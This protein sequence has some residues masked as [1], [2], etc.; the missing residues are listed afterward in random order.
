MPFTINELTFSSG[1][2]SLTRVHVA[3]LR[4]WLRDIPTADITRRYFTVAGEAPPEKEVSRLILALRDQLIPLCHQH[5]MVEAAIGLRH[6][7][8]AASTH[9]NAALEAILQIESRLAPGQDAELGPQAGQG[10]ELWFTATLARRFQRAG[11]NTFQDILEAFKEHGGGWWRHAPR[12]GAKTADVVLRWMM[13]QTSLAEAS[14]MAELQ[15]EYLPPVPAPTG[16]D[17]VILGPSSP[18]VPWE[19]IKSLAST[20]DGTQGSNRGPRNRMDAQNDLAAIRSWLSLH[21][22]TSHTH[23]AY[24]KEAERF[25]LW[26]ILERGKPLSSLSTEDAIA[27]RDF[28]GNIP[29]HWQGP[30]K[31]RTSPLWRPFALGRLKPQPKP[32]NRPAPPA[33]MPHEPWKTAANRPPQQEVEKAQD[34]FPP[35]NAKSQVQAMTILKALCEWLMRRGYLD[36]NPFDGVPQLNITDERLNLRKAFPEPVWDTLVDWLEEQSQPPANAQIRAARAAILV[37]RD[38]GLRRAEACSLCR[39]DLVYTVGGGADSWE[40]TVMGKGRKRRTI[41]TS[42]R[43]VAAL[44]AHFEDR[45]QEWETPDNP[46]LLSPLTLI[47]DKA[48]ERHAQA[49]AGY[50]PGS[51]YHLVK[52][53]YKA[54]AAAHGDLYGNVQGHS[55]KTATVHALRH[56]FGVHAVAAGVELDVLQSVLGHAS[57][58]T[59]TI[60]VQGDRARRRSQLTE[61]LYR[62]KDKKPDEV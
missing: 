27:Y 17:L 2:V 28:L 8:R 53:T 60:Y 12:I 1:Q 14:G 30:P 9:L 57:L 41:P 37:L 23:R 33:D 18:L 46:P 48:Q 55:M 29:L 6:G 52:A 59:T 40:I 5:G 10:V 35:L 21:P 47:S 58:T 15:A 44:K 34:R 3:A 42:E 54:F 24:R 50:T 4:S 32:Q 51:L 16:K 43:A 49:E 39:Q 20:L 19:R 22:A 61:K 13:K 26:A 62:P 56:T 45:R 11:L 25:L 36:S 38:S 7:P 31:A